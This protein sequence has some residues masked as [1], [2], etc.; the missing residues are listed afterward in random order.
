[1]V[2]KREWYDLT[3]Q[4]RAELKDRIVELTISIIKKQNT[5]KDMEAEKKLV[6]EELKAESAERADLAY[7]L[8]NSNKP[9][10]YDSP[11]EL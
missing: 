11:V 5:V 6:V 9:E 1:M 10:N 4:D 8:D 3:E 7:A 2:E